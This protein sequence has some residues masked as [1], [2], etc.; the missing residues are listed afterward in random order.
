M[1]WGRLVRFR[2]LDAVPRQLRLCELEYL[3]DVVYQSKHNWLCR[4]IRVR[5]LSLRPSNGCVPG[6][7]LPSWYWRPVLLDTTRLSRNP[8]CLGPGASCQNGSSVFCDSE[9]DCPAGQICCAVGTGDVLGQWSTS[10][11]PAADCHEQQGG[12]VFGL[13]VCDPSLTP[14]ECPGAAACLTSFFNVAYSSC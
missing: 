14:T 11:M 9:A 6:S 4:R 13:Q 8:T 1:Q 5:Q 10:C 7:Q 3:Q 2:Q 12:V